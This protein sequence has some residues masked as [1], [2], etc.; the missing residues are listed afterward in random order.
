ML[1]SVVLACM[2]TLLHPIAAIA[3]TLT[4]LADIP[5]HV[6]GAV[7]GAALVELNGTFYGTTSAGGADQAG[8]IFQ[9][10]LSTGKENL[11]YSFA[12]DAVLASVS[13]LTVV[14]G[15]LYGTTRFKDATDG[16][17]NRIGWPALRNGYFRGRQ[18][19]WLSL[20]N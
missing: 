17:I 14:A 5:A 13:P 3:G 8:T 11:L 2:A 19:R 6:D 15:K 18:R 7:P 20:H 16:G 10:D 12:G 4:T 9:L 1:R